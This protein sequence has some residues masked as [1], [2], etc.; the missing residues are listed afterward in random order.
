MRVGIVIVNYNGAKFQNECIRS[1]F[2]TGFPFY[3]IIIVDNGSTD[4]S[5]EM[6]NEF[7]DDKVEK[8]YC[9][10]NFGVAK[11]NN[12]G[13]ERS[14]SLGCTHSLLLN[15]DTFIPPDFFDKFIGSLGK[16]DYVAVPK[17]YFYNSDLFWYAGG[18]FSKFKCN[19]YH[20][21]YKEQEGKQKIPE[22][23]DYAPTC[24]MLIDNT[25]FDKIGLMDENYFLYFDDTDFC[26][27]LKLAGISIRLVKDA[28]IYHK[29]SLSSGGENS[30][31][32]VYYGNRNRFY[33]HNKFKKY[34]SVFSGFFIR[35]TRLLKYLK[36]CIK[37]DNNRLIKTAIKDYK[38]GKMGRAGNLQELK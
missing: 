7:P 29:V 12:I 15:N 21:F 23:C 17:I 11:G 18:A 16:G 24:C 37:K 25:V 27:R 31:I 5:M 22:F 13:I 30:I 10:E 6:L 35:S 14:I 2:E 8:I 1:I 33:F 36:G 26:F 38:A 34:F 32:T 9:N 28:S 4:G 19:S 3:K 20:M